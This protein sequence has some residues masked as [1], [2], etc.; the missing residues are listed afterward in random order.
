MREE[1]TS[2]TKSEACWSVNFVLTIMLTLGVDFL[3][4]IVNINLYAEPNVVSFYKP[5]G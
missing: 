2:T 1:R 3:Q 4:G 5:L